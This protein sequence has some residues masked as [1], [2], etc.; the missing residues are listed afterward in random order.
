[1]FVHIPTQLKFENRKQAIAVMGSKRYNIA[2]AK[3]EFDFTKR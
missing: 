3:K 2:L 1:M